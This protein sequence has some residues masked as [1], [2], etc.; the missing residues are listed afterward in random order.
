MS[1]TQP[2]SP[3]DDPAV[4]PCIAP[5]EAPATPEETG[6]SFDQLT[7]LVLKV[8]YFSEATGTEVADR[9][10]ISYAVF[11]GFVQHARAERLVEVRGASGTGSA[12]YQYALTDLGRDRARQYL[13]VCQY[14]GPLP[15]R[16]SSTWLRSGRWGRPARRSIESASRPGART[17]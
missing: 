2:S 5:P 3:T 15:C 9:L 16:W 12:A 11:D 10:H 13:D 17:W 1:M 7:Q 6:L 4:D 8:L 14:V